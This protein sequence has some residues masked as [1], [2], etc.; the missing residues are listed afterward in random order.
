M[1][2]DPRTIAWQGVLGLVLVVGGVL[3]SGLTHSFIGLLLVLPGAYLSGKVMGV[4]VLI[5]SGR[6]PM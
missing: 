4:L 6:L 2:I 5:L 3:L 1:N